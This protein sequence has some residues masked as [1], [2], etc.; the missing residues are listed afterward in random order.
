MR[1]YIL[2]LPD[3]TFRCLRRTIRSTHQLLPALHRLPRESR[4]SG[5]RLRGTTSA[6]VNW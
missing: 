4:T 3:T 6:L 5:S 2:W 1:F